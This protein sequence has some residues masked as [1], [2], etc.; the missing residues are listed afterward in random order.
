M[1]P[2][3]EHFDPSFSPESN[4]R[5]RA[6]LHLK[7]AEMPANE[8]AEAYR[9]GSGLFRVLLEELARHP[10]ER[11]TYA[12]VEAA[13]GW[14][15]RRLAAVLGGYGNRASRYNGR[16]PYRIFEE[17]DGTWWIWMDHSRAQII[18]EEESTS[19][20]DTN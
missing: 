9:E 20:V 17:S 7:S 15:R 8:V 11:R 18:R 19:P 5:R 16:R 2:G 4:G 6:K 3:P 10:A 14:E 1:W 13:L 12:N